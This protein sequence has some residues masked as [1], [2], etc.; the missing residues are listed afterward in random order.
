MKTYGPK[1]LAIF[2]VI[3]DGTSKGQR[4][5]KP[6][7]DGWNK[8][9]KPAGACGLDPRRVSTKYYYSGG[10]VG[11]PYNI[12]LDAKTR[13]IVEKKVPASQLTS[14]FQKYLN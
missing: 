1:G 3:N 10:P 2:Q 5:T 8:I 4:P 14:M 12:L 11:I 13:K 9:Y 6:Q 7:L